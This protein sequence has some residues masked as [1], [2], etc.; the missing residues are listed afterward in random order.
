M[1]KL[2]VKWKDGGLSSLQVPTWGASLVGQGWSVRLVQ[3]SLASPVVMPA[4][5]C[6][7]ERGMLER[8]LLT[9]GASSILGP[10]AL[11]FSGTSRVTQ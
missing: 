11:C 10:L 4:G 2:P 9:A 7:W 5:S 8:W 3:G 1:E 6:D